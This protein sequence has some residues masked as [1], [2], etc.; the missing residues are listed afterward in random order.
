ML[1][2]G[3]ADAAVT[4]PTAPRRRRRLVKSDAWRAF[5]TLAS[6]TALLAFGM[7]IALTGVTEAVPKDSAATASPLGYTRSLVLF[8]AP[9]VVL[10]AWFARHPRTPFAAKAV[11]I[12]VGLLTPLGVVLDVLLARQL[13][14]FD[15]PATTLGISFPVLGGS[16]PIE[17]VI[18]YFTGF[19]AVLLT[20]VWADEYWLAHYNVPD[21]GQRAR[22]VMP[23]LS[24]DWRAVIA[25]A[26]IA[27]AATS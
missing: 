18:F 9:I 2:A 27:V 6:I 11:A 8:A 20:Y 5:W 16:V 12:T 25:G 15:R 26:A 17:E 7:G 13:L 3:D 21:L 4:R 19:L 23:L 10:L 1:G 22:S 24:W 14:R